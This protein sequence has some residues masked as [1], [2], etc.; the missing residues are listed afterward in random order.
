MRADS[1]LPP[2]VLQCR[3]PFFDALSGVFF[4]P[5]VPQSSRRSPLLIPLHPGVFRTSPEAYAVDVT[6]SS[7]S[8]SDRIRTARQPAPPRHTL[9]L[10]SACNC[11]S[12]SAK[13]HPAILSQQPQRPTHMHRK[14][15]HTFSRSC[16]YFLDVTLRPPL[17]ADPRLIAI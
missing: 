2:I 16:Q 6:E 11:P 9:P 8:A 10:E 12:G 17:P 7:P 5:P 3:P 15:Q 13:T 1:L 14:E 4:P